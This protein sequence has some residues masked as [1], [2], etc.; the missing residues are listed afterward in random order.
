VVPW[1]L[2]VP[3]SDVCRGSPEQGL[4]RKIFSGLVPALAPP[5]PVETG[6]TTAFRPYR[7]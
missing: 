6:S 1:A 5:V 3:V 7:R 2:T 4:N